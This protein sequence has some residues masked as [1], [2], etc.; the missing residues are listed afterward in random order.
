[1]K[2][3]PLL[4]SSFVI[5][6]VLAIVFSIFIDTMVGQQSFAASN[7]VAPLHTSGNQ[8][9]D[10]NNQIVHLR[11]LNESWLGF[12]PDSPNGTEQEFIQTKAWGANLVRI[13]MNEEFG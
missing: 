13:L 4:L 12:N 1:M 8:I 5:V 11:G 3:T 2:L 10:A 9:M 7:Y 6:S